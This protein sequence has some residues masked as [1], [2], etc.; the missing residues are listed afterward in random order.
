MGEEMNT[1]H[2][3]WIIPA[4]AMLGVLWG[5]SAGFY[6]SRQKHARMTAELVMR[7]VESERDKQLKKK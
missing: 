7:I 5:L 2:L 3:I 6:F 4:T 1:L